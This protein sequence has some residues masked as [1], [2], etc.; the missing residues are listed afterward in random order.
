VAVGEAGIPTELPD[1]TLP[2][3]EPFARGGR[4]AFVGVEWSQLFTLEPFE[5]SE[6]RTILLSTESGIPLLVEGRVGRGRVLLFTGTVDLDWGN[7]PLQSAFMPFVQRLV[8]YLGGATGGD[9]ARVSGQVDQLVSVELLDT[10]APLEVHGPSGTVAAKITGTGIAFEPRV[11]GAYRVVTPGAPPL[12]HV[13]VNT[14]ALESDVRPGPELISLA[15]EVDPERYQRREQFTL[16]FLLFA[17]LCA[18]M[19]ALL[20]RVVERRRVL[21]AAATEQGGSHAA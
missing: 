3:F 9:G 7:F 18:G 21:A 11:A 16:H 12:A 17:L 15:A 13:A 2:L 20:A 1:T 19:S 14:S 4:S 10:T 5:S 8:S 6:T